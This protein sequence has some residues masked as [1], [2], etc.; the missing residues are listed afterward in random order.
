M[1]PPLQ[2]QAPTTPVAV[3]ADDFVEIQD[4]TYSDHSPWTCQYNGLRARSACRCAVLMSFLFVTP[5]NRT[6]YETAQPM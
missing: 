3:V 5:K 1:R 6:T 4:G 2:W